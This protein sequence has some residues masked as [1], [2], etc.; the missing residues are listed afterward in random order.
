MRNLVAIVAIFLLIETSVIGQEIR[1]RVA[2]QPAPHYVHE[3]VMIQFTVEGFE[4]GIDPECRL[5]NAGP[6]IDGKVVA[7]NPSV[8]S[9]V[10]QRNGQLFRSSTVTYQIHYEI[11]VDKPG[12]YVVGPFILQQGERQSRVESLNMSFV[13]IPPDPDMRVRIVMT[14]SPLYLQQ[15]VPVSVEWWYAGDFKNVLDLT[16]RCDLFDRFNFEKDRVPSERDSRLVIDTVKGRIELYAEAREERVNGK[17]F[18]VLYAKR[19]LI[20]DEIGIFNVAAITATLQQAKEWSGTSRSRSN[21]GFGGLLFQDLLGESRQPTRTELS[22]TQG[23]AKVFEIKNLPETGRPDSFSGAVG[24]GFSM[25]VSADRTVCRV[26]DPI[27]LDI[28]IRGDGNLADTSLP[29]LGID[30]GLNP[31]QFQF[32]DEDVPG[33]MTDGSK[34][35]QVSFR[36]RDPEVKEI[37]GLPLSWFDPVRERYQTHRSRPIALQVMDASVVSANDVV[38]TSS[39]SSV[40]PESARDSETRDQARPIPSGTAD[41]AIET[42]IDILLQNSSSRELSPVMRIPGYTCGVGAIVIGWVLR[43]RRDRDPE[44]IVRD[45]RTQAWLRQINSLLQSNEVDSAE[46]VARVMRC[47]IPET[48]PGLHEEMERVIATCDSITY[49]PTSANHEGYDFAFRQTVRSLVDR[50]QQSSK[51]NQSEALVT[52][53]GENP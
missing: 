27:L 25:E 21:R 53:E 5:E 7:I 10:I 45:R 9:Q 3:P 23:K 38:R 36:V 6:G 39:E 46:E 19:T 24:S 34:H 42:D 41:L 26:G 50:I 32:S 16:I 15:R 29:I 4:E 2:I 33:V 11:R 1:V 14:D 8:F 28:V 49:A 12:D 44:T 22:Q 51:G 13:Q 48:S 40:P 17:R 30:D 52:A 31:E 35:F 43:R 37:P 47:L 20:P 18:T